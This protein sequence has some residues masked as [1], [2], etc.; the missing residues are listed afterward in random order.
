MAVTKGIRTRATPDWFV[1]YLSQ[2]AGFV[3]NGNTGDFYYISLFNNSIN[4]AYFFVYG[5][6]PV[7][8]VAPYMYFFQVPEALGALYQNCQRVN[9]TIGAPAGQIYTYDNGS[10]PLANQGISLI[11][12]FAGAA[13]LSPAP[14]FII[15]P[16]HSLVAATAVS[17][18]APAC[19]FTY[20]PMLDQYGNAPV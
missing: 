20:V 1:R 18:T 9:P 13:V 11:A 12:T 16:G 17:D 15:P 8:E 3:F 10:S 2:G 19:G 14:L 7:A 6:F 5:A 4:G